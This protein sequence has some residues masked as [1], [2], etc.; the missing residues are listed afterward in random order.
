MVLMAGMLRHPRGNSLMKATV[1]T[2]VMYGMMYGTTVKFTVAIMVSERFEMR[3]D[4]DLVERLDQW[5]LAEDDTPSRAEAVRRLIEAGLAHDNKGR[6][7][8]LSDG[9]KLIAVMLGDLIKGLDVEVDTNVDLVQKVIYGG[10]YWALGWEM[11][12]IF[13][14]HADKQTRVRFVVDVLDMWSFMEEAFEGFSKA[15]KTRLATEADPW[16]KHVEFPGFDGNNESEYLGIARFLTND[17]ERFSRF[18]EGKRK[19]ELNSHH[20]TLET[21]GKMLR[22]FEPIRKTLV[23]RGLTVDELVAIFNGRKAS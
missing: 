9:E 1:D 16:G 7:P 15:D 11:Q 21:Y 17:L 5:R 20:P 3:I 22:V 23:G 10:H 4:S 19:R 12:G 2:A 8:H 18:R 14:G 6:T 13:H